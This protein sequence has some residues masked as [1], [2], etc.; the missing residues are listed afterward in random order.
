MKWSKKRNAQHRA[1]FNRLKGA[2]QSLRFN[3]PLPLF[4]IKSPLTEALLPL[5]R[6]LV[7]EFLPGLFAGFERK[8]YLC[9]R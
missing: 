3:L 4:P 6:A 5:P 9:R 7:F 8:P 2:L 1:A